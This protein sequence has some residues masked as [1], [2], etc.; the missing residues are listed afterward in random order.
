MLARGY[1][2]GIDGNWRLKTGGAVCSTYIGKVCVKCSEPF[3]ASHKTQVYCSNACHPSFVRDN[4][5]W[6]LGKKFPNEKGG[7]GKKR[8]N[9]MGYI[10]VYLP[11]HPMSWKRGR[12]LEHRLVMSKKI[13]R[14]LLDTEHVHHINGIKNDNRVENLIILTSAEHNSHHKS[15]EV[16]HRKR[17]KLGRLI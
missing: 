3:A 12:I 17:D 2:Q 5:A 15:E 11:T 13:G 10:E 16:K 9:K 7:F 1:E 4:P 14:N 8:L 6:R